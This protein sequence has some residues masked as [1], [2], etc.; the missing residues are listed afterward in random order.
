ERESRL[1]SLL[2]EYNCTPLSQKKI[3][4]VG[5]GYGPGV[6]E[7]I[8]WGA[9]PENLVGIDLLPER[10]AEARRLCPTAV[11]LE[12][13]NAERLQFASGSFDLVLQS[14]VFSSILDCDVRKRV[15]QEI[16]RMLKPGG[17]ILWYDFFV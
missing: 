10:I 13:G 17:S 11:T 4:E 3:L 12:T 7:F 2:A 6:R 1:L 15:A 9:R 5:C 16:L 8:K 14:T